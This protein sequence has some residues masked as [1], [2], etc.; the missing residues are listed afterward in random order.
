MRI[1]EN[2]FEVSHVTIFLLIFFAIYG[3][4]DGF[5]IHGLCINFR[6]SI[7]ERIIREQTTE[8]SSH[9]FRDIEMPLIDVCMDMELRG[10]EIRE[11]LC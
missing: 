9:V 2:L 10:V 11:G 8:S 5:K 7:L 1:L 4:N 6:K 3:A